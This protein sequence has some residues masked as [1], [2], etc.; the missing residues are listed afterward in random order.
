MTH[1]YKTKAS[2]Y[3]KNRR[4]NFVKKATI[5]L[6]VPSITSSH[7]CKT[8]GILLNRPR[9]VAA[10]VPTSLWKGNW[11]SKSLMWRLVYHRNGAILKRDSSCQG[12]YKK[13]FYCSN[14]HC[15]AQWICNE[16]DT[17]REVVV[18]EIVG[19]SNS[20]AAS[21]FHNVC[22][23][24]GEGKKDDST[25][26]RWFRKF[27]VGDRISQDQARS[28]TCMNNRQWDNSYLSVLYPEI[29]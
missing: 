19:Q 11:A 17:I 13:L 14:T 22:Q 12:M 6:N 16:I 7:P 20:T 29:E 8:V 9:I 5:F 21:A 28:M 4:I 23:V 26:R 24:Y 2:Y 25:C 15:G 1:F 10:L 18:T 3:L 27:Q